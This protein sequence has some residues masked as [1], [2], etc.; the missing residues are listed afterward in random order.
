[1][2]RRARARANGGGEI[3]IIGGALAALG[4]GAYF[5][6]KPAASSTVAIKGGTPAPPQLGSPTDSNSVAYACNT[7]WK[8]TALG[9]PNQAAV[10]VTKCTQGGGAVPQAAS[11]Q[12]V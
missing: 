2:K 12:Y 10:W 1:M 8:L 4:I 9:H 7:A 6:F 3:L 5:L 11:Q